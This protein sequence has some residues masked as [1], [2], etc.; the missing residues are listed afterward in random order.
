MSTEAPLDPLLLPG[1]SCS[2]AWL[3]AVLVR[4][5][6]AKA[7]LQKKLEPQKLLILTAVEC[8]GLEFQ[9]SVCAG[10]TKHAA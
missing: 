3:Q 8:K 4:D 5:E 6:E 2:W 1:T 7:Q 9:V 10:C